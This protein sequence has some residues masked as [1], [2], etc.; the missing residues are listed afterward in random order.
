MSVKHRTEN[1]VGSLAFLPDGR[2][3]FLDAA[4]R[5]ESRP[6][7][8]RRAPLP[9]T[10]GEG[11]AGQTVCGRR[12]V[13]LTQA[14]PVRGRWP[15]A[16]FG[17]WSPAPGGWESEWTVEPA[18]A[19]RGI[20]LDLTG[21]A[22]NDGRF[23]VLVLP[24]PDDHRRPLVCRS[25]ATGEV[26]ARAPTPVAASELTAAADGSLV[27]GWNVEELTM[28]RPGE[29][30]RT[31]YRMPAGR[32]L[33]DLTGAA[34]HPSGGYAAA[35]ADDGRVRLFDLASG[36]MIREYDWRVGGLHCVAFSPDGTLGAAGTDDGRVVLWDCD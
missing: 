5:F 22:G 7:G 6:A 16:R 31:L 10:E 21:G 28:W 18:A 32:G 33:V 35:T 15:P 1:E 4:A 13:A 9:G 12:V 27:V 11:Y 19:D 24:H 36:A 25:G 8:S 14:G 17:G 29:D 2:L 34:V 20:H 30:P 23:Y 3:S 26:V